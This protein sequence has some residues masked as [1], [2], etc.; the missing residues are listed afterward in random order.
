MPPNLEVLLVNGYIN[1]GV[2]PE[3]VTTHMALPDS[4][5]VCPASGEPLYTDDIDG[6]SGYYYAY[7]K[8]AGKVARPAMLPIAWDKENRHDGVVNVLYADMHVA[9]GP[10]EML[11]AMA[12]DPT[13][14]KHYLEPPLMPEPPPEDSSQPQ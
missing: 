5:L 3:D 12:N 4:I 9:P 13:A 8:D 11:K 6:T 7:I 2:T 1:E 10:P 14:A